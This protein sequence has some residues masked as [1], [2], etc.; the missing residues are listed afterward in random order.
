MIQVQVSSDAELKTI[1][2]FLTHAS[3]AQ[4]REHQ[5]QMT[6]VPGLILTGVTFCCCFLS[7]HVVKPLMPI[8]PL[9]LIWGVC[10][11]SNMLVYRI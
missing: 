9:M 3:I 6:E 1:L 8:L 10:E 4:R 2:R 11:N 7:F 5:I